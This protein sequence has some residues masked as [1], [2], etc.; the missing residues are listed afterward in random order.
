MTAGLTWNLRPARAEGNLAITTSP[1][2]ELVA[3]LDPYSFTS[4]RTYVN[5]KWVGPVENR[6]ADVRLCAIAHADM[7][8]SLSF[9]CASGSSYNGPSV[10]VTGSMQFDDPSD[11]EPDGSL[12]FGFFSTRDLILY[13][14]AQN[15]QNGEWFPSNVVFAPANPLL[16]KLGINECEVSQDGT[17]CRQ[18]LSPQP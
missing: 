7:V 2:R 17:T 11:I 3:T 14:E 15:G 1:S 8:A 13:V 9:P 16:L 5:A 4:P 10:Q 6:P 18:L 12:G